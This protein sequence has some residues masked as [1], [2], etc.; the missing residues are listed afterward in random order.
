MP[1]LLHACSEE[2][3]VEAR[4]ENV[5]D[6]Q[7]ESLLTSLLAA[8]VVVTQLTT[9]DSILRVVE[10][11]EMRLIHAGGARRLV[12]RK[13]MRSGRHLRVRR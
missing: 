8:L 9:C 7:R 5:Q 6:I 4:L 12:G 2:E 10:L 3:R 1:T 11:F 13:S